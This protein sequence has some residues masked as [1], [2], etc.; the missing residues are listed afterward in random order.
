MAQ[1][2]Y[3]PATL[4]SCGAKID[5]KRF[6]SVEFHHALVQ[7]S[8]GNDNKVWLA[9][10]AVQH[11]NPEL[12]LRIFEFRSIQREPTEA[13]QRFSQHGGFPRQEVFPVFCL[14]RNGAA[15]VAVGY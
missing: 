13:A 15:V 14:D 9:F 4:A 1:T 6:V 3:L 10:E 11:K 7:F 2:S 8:L 5:L 12:S